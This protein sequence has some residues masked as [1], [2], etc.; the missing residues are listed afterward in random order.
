MEG[1][2]ISSDLEIAP[3]L[4]TAISHW[5]TVHLLRLRFGPIVNS[6][7]QLNIEH[8]TK[9][10]NLMHINVA[11]KQLV[12]IYQIDIQHRATIVSIIAMVP[13]R[14]AWGSTITFTG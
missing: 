8:H 11:G 9:V 1:K 6:N 12:H 3:L 2:S 7:E 5:L 4:S 10:N 14:G 13:E